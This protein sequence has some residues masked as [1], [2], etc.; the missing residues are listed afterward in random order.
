MSG[1]VWRHVAAALEAG[2]PCIGVDVILGHVSLAGV[3][4]GW[5]DQA[6]RKLEQIKLLHR[7]E[8]LEIG[9]LVGGEG[10]VA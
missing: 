5:A 6:S 3:A 1:L 7:Q 9:L 2:L 8:A 4:V 10:Y